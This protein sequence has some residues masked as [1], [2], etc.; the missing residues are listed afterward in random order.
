M[1]L[2]FKKKTKKQTLSWNNH[3]FFGASMIPKY[4]TGKERLF[5]VSSL[6]QKWPKPTLTPTWP[7]LIHINQLFHITHT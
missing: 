6:K 4:H 2:L 5:L 7:Q 3:D 1:G